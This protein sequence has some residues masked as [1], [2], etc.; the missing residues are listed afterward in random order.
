MLHSLSAPSFLIQSNLYPTSPKPSPPELLC[1][2]GPTAKWDHEEPA[3]LHLTPWHI[4]VAH[5]LC[6]TLGLPSRAKVKMSSDVTNWGSDQVAMQNG[7]QVGGWHQGH[8]LGLCRHSAKGRCTSCPS[9]KNL[10]FSALNTERNYDAVLH[11][12][13]VLL[14]NTSRFYRIL[15]SLDLDTWA[16]ACSK[17]YTQIIFQTPQ[18]L[19]NGKMAINSLIWRELIF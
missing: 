5:F 15:T 16:T 1:F 3:F 10:L 4:S 13:S 17:R 14:F 19:I 7:E 18:K 12:E 6:A 8:T 2:C 9:M 11:V